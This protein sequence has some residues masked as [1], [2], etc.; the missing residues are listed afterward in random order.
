MILSNQLVSWLKQKH[1]LQQ[2]INLKKVKK[3]YS[4]RKEYKERNLE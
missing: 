1:I 2:Q 3:K 4:E